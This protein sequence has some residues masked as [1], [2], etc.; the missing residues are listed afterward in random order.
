MFNMPFIIYILGIPIVIALV[1]TL[2][3]T[4]LKVLLTP[5]HKQQKGEYALVH[6]NELLQLILTKDIKR[7]SAILIKGYVNYYETTCTEE[8]CPLK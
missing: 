7:E 3:D 1:L 2:R 4:G 5:L 6:I 8:L